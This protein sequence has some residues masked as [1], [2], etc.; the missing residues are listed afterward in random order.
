MPDLAPIHQLSRRPMLHLS[1][2]YFD[3]IDDR[4]PLQVR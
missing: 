3:Q 4:G 1:P 2:Q